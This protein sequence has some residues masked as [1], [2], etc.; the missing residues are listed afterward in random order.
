M[1]SPIDKYV[2]PSGVGP[3]VNIWGGP[4]S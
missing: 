4:M 3:D 2:R 1:L